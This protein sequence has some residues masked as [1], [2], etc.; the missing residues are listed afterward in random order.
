MNLR[1]RPLAARAAGAEDA[2]HEDPEAGVVAQPPQ[3]QAECSS[4]G[5]VGG[6]AWQTFRTP[7]KA[8]GRGLAAVAAAGFTLVA[9]TALFLLLHAT[10]CDCL[11]GR[12]APGAQRTEVLRPPRFLTARAVGRAGRGS[13]RGR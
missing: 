2:A 3:Q 9:V 12:S 13:G 4:G 5:A 8:G 10:D 11:R 6:S 1:P 7:A